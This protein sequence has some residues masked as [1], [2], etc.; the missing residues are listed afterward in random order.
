MALYP[1]AIV[2]IL[3]GL[4]SVMFRQH[5]W[6]F[7]LSLLFTAVP[8]LLDGL[9]A[10]GLQA[11]WCISILKIGQFL[12]GFSAGLGWTV[13]ALVGAVLGILCDQLSSRKNNS[14]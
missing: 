1:F 8:A 7:N 10:T 5:R 14:Q 6:L 4:L 13:P 12:P 2:L 3:V 11:S 9:N